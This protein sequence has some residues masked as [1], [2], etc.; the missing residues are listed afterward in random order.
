MGLRLRKVKA[1]DV[2]NSLEK[3]L[4]K[5]DTFRRQNG[6]SGEIDNVHEVLT[7]MSDKHG[8]ICRNIKHTER[9]DP[10]DSWQKE[11]SQALTGYIVYATMLLR[12]Y[13]IDITSGLVEE[14]EESVKQHGKS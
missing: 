3:F 2:A 12:R 6:L 9:S 11:I 7:A 5:Y 8:R 14:L 4:Y 10:K 1:T 13:K